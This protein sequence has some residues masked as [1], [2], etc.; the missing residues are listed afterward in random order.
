MT[1]VKLAPRPSPTDNLDPE[2][3]AADLGLAIGRLARRLRQQGNGGVTASLLSALWTIERLGPITL[4]DLAT[5]ERVQ[6]PTIT[7]IVSRLEESALVTREVDPADRRVARIALT[8]QGRRLL[9]TTRSRRTA[10]LAKAL[11]SVRP[12]DRAVLAR[13]VELMDDLIRERG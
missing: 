10:Y 3:L 5:A 1:H 12:E 9:D 11:R 2:R 7:R 8:G 13:A 6:P 4:G